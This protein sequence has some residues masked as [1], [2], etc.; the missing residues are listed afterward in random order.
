M[1]STRFVKIAASGFVIGMTLTGG[2]P[3]P[4]SKA[5]AASDVRQMQIAAKAAAKATA[6][7]TDRNFKAAVSAAE[8][9][10]LAQPRDPQ[11]RLLLG[12]AYLSGG[13]FVSAERAFS[14][15]LTLSPDNARAALNL[16]LA[17]IALGK[18]D[19]ARAT[20]TDYADRLSPSD[21]GLA[22]ALA[23][24]V[25][26][27]VQT[28]ESTIRGGSTD[29]K[30]RQNL[31]LAYAMAGNWSAARAM[32]GQDLAGEDLNN[33]IAQW[34]SFV[35]PQAQADQVASLLGVKPVQ[36]GGQPAQLA[37]TIVPAPTQPAVQA[38]A[39]AAPVVAPTPK[40]EP[41]AVA[42]APV[43]ETT[44][45]DV[46][47]SLPAAPI[48][49]ASPTAIKQIIVPA[50]RPVRLEADAPKAVERPTR[51]V[52]AGKFV[53]QLGAF[54]SAAVS[55]DAWRRLA[56]RYGLT[57]FDPANARATVR[58]ATYIRLSVGGFT[59]RAEAVG[60]CVRIRSAG[61]SCFVRGLIN[62]T[63][64]YWVQRGMPKAVKSVR[65]ASR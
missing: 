48:I 54:A 24:D 29:A 8:T 23:G 2:H 36:D 4:S 20:L 39:I 6:A 53:V 37:L 51:S 13:R 22:L 52:E 40:R 34:A 28:L 30:T 15:V 9:A 35:Q 32:A 3:G 59:T 11:Y 47:V 19:G 56:P 25:Q 18:R 60:V 43:F 44:S 49:R 58:G 38:A 65:I 21:Y 27:G 5:E 16:A 41:V 62:D 42:Q 63:P 1:I 45:N 50:S 10:V 46:A 26:G 7:L 17:E 61:G 57:A 55:K 64:A 12:Q 31:A 33:R 14:D